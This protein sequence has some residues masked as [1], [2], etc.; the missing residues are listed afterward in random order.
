MTTD[1]EFVSPNQV[2]KY[3]PNA[4]Q[5]GVSTVARSAYGF[6]RAFEEANGDPEA[7]KRMLCPSGTQTWFEK[8]E[9]FLKTTY[10]QYAKKMSYRRWLSMIMW[11]YK[12]P[13]PRKF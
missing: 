9:N 4:E 1:F 5:E 12:A 7:L 8:R 10:V 13:R 6:V 11:A 2:K 3:V